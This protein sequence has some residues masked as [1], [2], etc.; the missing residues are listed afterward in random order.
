MRI[1]VSIDDTALSEVQQITGETQ[2]SK[3]V[4]KAVTAF[5][6]QARAIRFTDRAAAGEL[7]GWFDWPAFDE[8]ERIS[9]ADAEHLVERLDRRGDR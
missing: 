5:I 3:A 4:A 8:A 1:S 9:L 6:R 2:K 7:D